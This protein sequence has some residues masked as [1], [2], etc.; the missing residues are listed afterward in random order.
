MAAG[1]G[2]EQGKQPG[3]CMDELSGLGTVDSLA[4]AFL[5]STPSLPISW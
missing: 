2:E 3:G 4:L 5:V 1:R